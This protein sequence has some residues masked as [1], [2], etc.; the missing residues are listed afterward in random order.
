MKG[1]L[2]RK[3]LNSPD[4]HQAKTC[5]VFASLAGF[6]VGF[7]F[8]LAV[9][10]L[11]GCAGSAGVFAATSTTEADLSA[12]PPI[13][14]ATLTAVSTV[15][16]L[17]TPTRFQLPTATP[18][19]TVQPAELQLSATPTCSDGLRFLADLTI[20]DGAPVAAGET[21]DKRWQVE[22]NGTCNWDARYHVRLISGSG[23][24]APAEQALY[25]ARSGARAVI[26]MLLIAPAEVGTFR[27]AW[28]AF[29][30]RGEAFG[31]P[32]YVEIL[33]TGP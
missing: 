17:P 32:F 18:T 15:F 20:P 19:F 9:S 28:Q 6:A 24:G 26:R 11:V 5:Q 27:S 25:P 4:K 30:P 31:D 33:V 16:V 14:E 22:N 23:L 21:I 7:V 2:L 3:R 29:N 12:A 1:A 8:L 10:I 13:L